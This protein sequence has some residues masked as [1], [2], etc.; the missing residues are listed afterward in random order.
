MP[1]TYEDYAEKRKA[2]LS[3]EGR[4][5]VRVFNGAYAVGQMIAQARKTRGYSQTQLSEL[6]GVAQ[7]DIS[8]IERG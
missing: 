4:S 5:A 1:K 2:R 7:A 6:S 8:R 3:P